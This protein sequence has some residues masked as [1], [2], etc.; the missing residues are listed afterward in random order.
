M[1][2]I[3]N[4]ITKR[5]IDTRVTELMEFVER[6]GDLN[7]LLTRIL[8]HYLQ[9]EGVC[10]KTMEDILGAMTGAQ[11]EFYRRVVAPYEDAKI[12]LNGDVYGGSTSDLMDDH[13]RRISR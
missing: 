1:P 9:R 12:A 6:S 7:F 13:L 4:G 5:E 11:A 8:V 2:Y 10:Y 3:D